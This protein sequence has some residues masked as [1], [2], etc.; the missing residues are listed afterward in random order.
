MSLN[1]KQESKDEL[2]SL[3]RYTKGVGMSDVYSLFWLTFIFISRG[4]EEKKKAAQKLLDFCNENFDFDTQK[5][6]CVDIPDEILDC[7]LIVS[8]E[9]ESL[10]EHDFEDDFVVDF[11]YEKIVLSKYWAII[12]AWL[13]ESF[14]DRVDGLFD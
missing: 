1:T 6:T 8:R 5:W 7:A 3:L 9:K 10:F 11:I 12:K 13:K 4:M 2:S 14:E